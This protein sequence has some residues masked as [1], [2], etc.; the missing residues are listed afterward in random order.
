MT[1]RL[2]RR[3]R[4]AVLIAF[5]GMVWGNFEPLLPDSHDGH[6]SDV[7]TQVIG[8]NDDGPTKGSPDGHPA[9]FAH[10][11]HCVHSHNTSLPQPVV[12]RFEQLHEVGS[13]EDPVRSVPSVDLPPH[14]RPPVA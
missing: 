3:F 6:G 8:Q 11:C 2:P 1:N 4:V 5:L 14:L 12:Q 10:V 7:A 13:F 9:G